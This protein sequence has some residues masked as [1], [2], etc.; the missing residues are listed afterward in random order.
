LIVD[1]ATRLTQALATLTD[2]LGQLQIASWRPT[3]LTPDV[4]VMI[5]CLPDADTQESIIDVNWGERDL[6]PNERVFGWNSFTIL[7]MK[8]GVP[9]APVN[10]IS[11]SAQ[12]T[13][14]LRY[15]AVRILMPYCPTFASILITL[16]LR[17]LLFLKIIWLRLR[18]RVRMQ[19]IF[20]CKRSCV[21]W[22]MALVD[23]Y[24][25]YATLQGHC[26]TSIFQKRLAWPQSGSRTAI[27]NVLSMRQTNIC[28]NGFFILP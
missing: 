1:P 13:C 21:P 15:V 10:A 28:R 17:M 5:A 25:F 8:S 26:Q 3:S 27:G 18:P 4:R 7:A 24:I 12:A 14:Q 20:G 23:Q 9:E 6:S 19:I 11:G 2:A 16:G 22:K